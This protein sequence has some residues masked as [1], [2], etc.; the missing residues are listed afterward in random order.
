MLCISVSYLVSYFT[1][2]VSGK[3]LLFFFNHRIFH[4]YEI[5]YYDLHYCYIVVSNML[6]FLL[7][8]ERVP[9]STN[10]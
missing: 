5:K 4:F 1:G 2:T 10:C 9:V 7:Q 6:P 3:G 8:A